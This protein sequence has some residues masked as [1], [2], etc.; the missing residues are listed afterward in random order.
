ML[1]AFFDLRLR[2]WDTLQNE[3]IELFVRLWISPLSFS[4]MSQTE[5]TAFEKFLINRKVSLL[6][7]C[8]LLLLRQ[9]LSMLL[10]F[11]KIILLPLNKFSSFL[12]V[13]LILSSKSWSLRWIIL[14]N[15]IFML[16]LV[17]YSLI[18]EITF[19]I[20]WRVF[21]LFWISFA[22]LWIIIK[23]GFFRTVGWT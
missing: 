6:F 13:S 23:V 18:E 7:K 9:V 19:L 5:F 3:T 8:N 17:S 15:A 2:K 4:F 22:S 12:L 20:F 1:P 11:I 16:S 21:T 10:L 14:D